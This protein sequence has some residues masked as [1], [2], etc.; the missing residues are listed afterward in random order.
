M[1]VDSSRV[2]SEVAFSEQI[3][4]PLAA[5]AYHTA[6]GAYGQRWIRRFI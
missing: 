2:I 4:A 1:C 5:V 6:N 3:Q